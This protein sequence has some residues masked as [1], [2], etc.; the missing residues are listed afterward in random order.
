M[1][2]NEVGITDTLYRCPSFDTSRALVAVK[3]RTFDALFADF[4]AVAHVIEHREQTTSSARAFGACEKLP[5]FQNGRASN[6]VTALSKMKD[7]GGRVQVPSHENRGG[8]FYTGHTTQR[9]KRHKSLTLKLVRGRHYDI[10]DVALNA[11]LF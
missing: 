4:D 11:R 9:E 3:G 6:L 2:I 7:S 5:G 1:V 8:E 10:G